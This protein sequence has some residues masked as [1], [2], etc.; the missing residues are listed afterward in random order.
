MVSIEVNVYSC[1]EATVMRD[2]RTLV[3]CMS[4]TRTRF[5]PLLRDDDCVDLLMIET[6]CAR[7]GPVII[8]SPG[9]RLRPDFDHLCLQSFCQLIVEQGRNSGL[10]ACLSL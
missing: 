4:E 8:L 2:E 5:F 7:W 3:P 1:V 9:W 10:G 6:T